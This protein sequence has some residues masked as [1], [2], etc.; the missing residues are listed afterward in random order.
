MKVSAKLAVV[1]AIVAFGSI[2]FEPRPA[3]AQIEKRA[4]TDGTDNT[5]IGHTPSRRRAGARLAPAR[6]GR[7]MHQRQP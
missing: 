2:G 5:A 4:A 1:I 6:L 7:A 3:A